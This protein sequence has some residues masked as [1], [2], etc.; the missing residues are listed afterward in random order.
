MSI[1]LIR[2]GTATKERLTSLK[3]T[4]WVACNNLNVAGDGGLWSISL[5]VV[6]PFHLKEAAGAQEVQRVDL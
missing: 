4:W 2:H 3:R 6:K 5:S 1:L